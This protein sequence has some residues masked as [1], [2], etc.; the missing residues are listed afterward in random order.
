MK[1]TIL[2]LS[3]MGATALFAVTVANAQDTLGAGAPRLDVPK[4]FDAGGGDADNLRAG[5]PYVGA[6]LGPVFQQDLYIRNAGRTVSMDT[7]VRGDL[8]AGFNVADNL[9]LGM[10]TGASSS[11]IRNSSVGVLG[12]NRAYLEQV[13]L[14]M[15]VILKA[16]LMGGVTPYIGGGI[17]GV[18]NDISVRQ[19][20]HWTD[21]AD[22]TFAY[23]AMAGVTFAFA[24]HFDVGLGYRFLGTP[25]HVFFPDDP[26]LYTP[27]GKIFSHSVLATFVFSF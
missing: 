1:K 22:A 7:G 8:F 13:P 26:T 25:D 18:V 11:R 4:I 19:N 6:D 9:A 27:T 16:P 3:A 2:Q 14:L 12:G 17:G 10:E 24:R 21:D 15:D 5:E 23:H 20:G